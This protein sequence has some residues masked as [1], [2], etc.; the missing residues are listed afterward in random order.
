MMEVK[1]KFKLVLQKISTAELQEATLLL[2]DLISH[3]ED[4]RKVDI[5]SG[6]CKL[7]TSNIS[8]PD[9]ISDAF[10]Y[11]I[12]TLTVQSV[13]SFNEA[14][15][16]RFMQSMYYIVKFFVAKGSYEAVA[17]MEEIIFP[18]I[19]PPSNLLSKKQQ[20]IFSATAQVILK[21]LQSI[22]V[23]DWT[24]RSMC[25]LTFKLSFYTTDLLYSLP[26][27]SSYMNLKMKN[28]TRETVYNCFLK[29][30][31]SKHLPKGYE[32]PFR[33]IL[34]IVT[35]V[36]FPF[37]Q[38]HDFLGYRVLYDHI[39]KCGDSIF[40]QEEYQH[41]HNILRFPLLL[42]KIDQNYTTSD[43]E[44]CKNS[45]EALDSLISSQKVRKDVVFI[46]DDLMK[47][48]M[49]HQS[50]A[51][52]WYQL[53]EELQLAC[54]NFIYDLSLF[55]SKQDQECSC[56]CS[57]KQTYQASSYVNRYVTTLIK[58]YITSGKPTEEYHQNCCQILE[59]FFGYIVQLK[60][61]NC[62]KLESC[63]GFLVV[64]TYNVAVKLLEASSKDALIY[65]KFVI[66]KYHEYGTKYSA[67]TLKYS[68]H[69]VCSLLA[70]DHED[71]LAI[72]AL[73]MYLCPDEKQTY[74]SIFTKAKYTM[75][76]SKEDFKKI[77][78]T[79]VFS[80]LKQHL[81]FLSKP[82]ELAK[83]EQ[84]TLLRFELEY[85]RKKW[86]SKVAMMAT[87]T[88]L[89]A[90]ADLDVVVQTL[91][92]VFGD[93]ELIVHETMPEVFSEILQRYEESNPMSNYNLAVMNFMS[94]RY[95]NQEART[96]NIAEMERVANFLVKTKNEPSGPEKEDPNEACDIVSG[97]DSLVLDNFINHLKFLDRALKLLSEIRCTFHPA[98]YDTLLKIYYEYRLHQYKIPA[99]RALEL[100]LEQAELEKNA[101]NI[102]TVISFIL[103][104][105][106]AS[107]QLVNDLIVEADGYLSALDQ[108]NVEHVKII[109][110]YYMS[111]SKA[112]LYTDY[113]QTVKYYKKAKQLL[114][115]WE[116]LDFNILRCH[117]NMLGHKII[118]LPCNQRNRP[119]HDDL[120]L[121]NIDLAISTLFEEYIERRLQG[122]Y[123]ML[124]LFEFAEELAKFYYSIRCPREVRSYCK[125][126]IHL[127]QKLVVPLRSASLL[128]YLSY[129]DLRTNRIDDAQYKLNSMAE[130]LCLNKTK[131]L[132]IP[133]PK[134]KTDFETEV[135]TVTD[136]LREMVLDE[137]EHSGYRSVSPIFD[138]QPFQIP[139]F[140]SHSK[141]CSCIFCSC[142][143]YQILVLEKARLDALINIKRENHTAAMDIL[144]SALQF[145]E[146]CDSRYKYL[147]NTLGDK[148]KKDLV[149]SFEDAAFQAYGSVLLDYSYHLR[150]T[151]N[152]DKAI[153]VNLKLLQLLLPRKAAYVY[154]HHEAA[155]QRLGYLTEAPDVVLPIEEDLNDELEDEAT[156]EFEKT[157]EG[158]KAKVVFVVSPEPSADELEPPKMSLRKI[159]FHLSPSPDRRAKTPAAKKSSS[160]STPAAKKSS[161]VSTPAAK[162][163][164]FTDA[165][166]TNKRSTRKRLDAMP[167]NVEAMKPP[168]LKN[169]VLKSKTKLLTEK[170]K[171]STKKVRDESV[172]CTSS[173]S[174]TRKKLFSDD[175]SKESDLRRSHRSKKNK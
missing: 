166:S 117:F 80:Q 78:L 172:E 107:T 125:E 48:A 99:L 42:A 46:M 150:R 147:Q 41:L 17:K 33:N 56:K 54:Y 91:V 162:I 95:K 87:F 36:L 23:P 19:L 115:K 160:V 100:A 159:P 130:I 131:I 8:T 171:Q 169:E 103:E 157:P 30:M 22:E 1:Q 129:A 170:L 47:H 158:K 128:Q 58:S 63:W 27:V 50:V 26:L 79:S 38:T 20:D 21:S 139:S 122:T 31:K 146:C 174:L 69:G 137:P 85:Y 168:V 124:L 57:S 64:S 61:N 120:S 44:L 153:D 144:A 45:L 12:L 133:E 49:A 68:L 121:L 145:Y 52:T 29:C 84:V 104:E 132:E 101:G 118:L 71:L 66:N 53:S 113:N 111:R 140:V 76:D 51:N 114:E 83:D 134:M 154:L 55:E 98:A 86:K 4:V 9:C 143:E 75:S 25:Q 127:A 102:M 164:I 82:I 151:G 109:A 92:D 175:P 135:G 37:A 5:I 156:K 155:M 18:K 67:A 136:S 65:F 163:S 167:N 72:S 148:L 97:F 106:D 149:P 60:E 59:K 35:S 14:S 32:E 6:C 73:A 2:R 165:C 28:D 15:L 74:M 13:E 90:V 105:S 161:S 96:K 24:V 123:G 40:K 10:L 93:G 126:V 11:E 43:V 16:L 142:L 3:I 34:H 108:S 110:M 89:I 7:C 119:Q 112:C 152:K 138:V 141:T 77:T 39:A 70:K 62:R 173:G 116:S 94:Y 88:E 81:S